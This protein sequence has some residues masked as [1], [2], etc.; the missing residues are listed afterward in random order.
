MT[1]NQSAAWKQ[2]WIL[3]LSCHRVRVPKKRLRE[4]L[5]NQSLPLG[6]GNCAAITVGRL[7]ESL[8]A[9]RTNSGAN[10]SCGKGSGNRCEL[11][12][13]I[14]SCQWYESFVEV[15]ILRTRPRRGGLSKRWTTANAVARAIPSPIGRRES[16]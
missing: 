9:P 1:I 14:N 12:L 13:T 5:Q 4:H 10:H 2:Q 6:G 11:A 8:G 16:R 7:G 15:N 3:S